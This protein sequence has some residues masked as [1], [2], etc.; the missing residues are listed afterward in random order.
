MTVVYEIAFPKQTLT[1]LENTPAE[2]WQR[3][4]TRKHILFYYDCSL[5]K[6]KCAFFSTAS[7]LLNLITWY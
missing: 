6:E 5:L 1:L 2:K 4:A 3:I 7:M